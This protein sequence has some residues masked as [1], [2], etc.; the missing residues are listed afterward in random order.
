M[1]YDYLFK[2]LLIGDSGCGKSSILQRFADEQFQS[3]YISTI[4]VDFKIRQ[5]EVDGKRVK[6][7]IWDTA[8]Q[9]RFRSI[10]S[11]YYRGAHGIFIC[12]NVTDANSFQNATKWLQE[13]SKYAAEDVA[14]ALLGAYA[15]L[16]DQTA[17][18]EKVAQEFADEQ[19]IAQFRVSAK[20][21]L[22]I[23]ESF[24]YLTKQVMSNVVEKSTAAAKSSARADIS[25]KDAAQKQAE[26]QAQQ[27]FNEKVADA[28]RKGQ[29]DEFR[30][31]KLMIVGQGRAG[32]TTTFESL[33]GKPFERHQQ[34]TVGATTADLS[35]T[36]D[37]KDIQS[38]EPYEEEGGEMRR[39]LQMAALAQL[40]E[41][42]QIKEAN[43]STKK[44]RAKLAKQ[45][46]TAAK[47]EEAE[48]SEQ[49]VASGSSAISATEPRKTEAAALAELSQKATK[50]MERLGESSSDPAA[51]SAAAMLAAQDVLEAARQ[52]VSQLT[53]DDID[54]AVRDMAED[55]DMN[56]TIS[57]GKPL[58]Y[59]VFDLGGQ[60]TFY[61]FHPFFLTK[62]AVYLVVFSMADLLAAETSEESWA[63]VEH[64]LGCI[65]LYAK[66]A[67]VFFV[68]THGDVVTRRKQHEVLSQGLFDRF[69]KHAAFPAVVFN[70]RSE[71]WFWPIDNTKSSK[72]SQITNLRECVSA[73]TNQQD[74]VHMSV[75]LPWMK[76][77][78]S[79]MDRMKTKNKQF[80][81]VDELAA[82][83]QLD[84]SAVVPALRFWH[85]YGMLLYYDTIPSM[86]NIVLLSPQW[87]VD[88]M[89]KVIRNFNLHRQ[90]QDKDARKLTT[91]WE[92]LTDNAV[93]HMSLLKVLWNQL[94]QELQFAFLS[95]MLQFGLLVP[96]TEQS[97]TD[98]SLDPTFL[99]PTL[100]PQ[101]LSEST[102]ASTSLSSYA[103]T[104][105]NRYLGYEA[106]VNVAYICFS[107]RDMQKEPAIKLDTLFQLSFIPEG[108]FARI[109]GQLLV[110]SQHNSRAHRPKLS[111]TS[112][113]IYF[114]DFKLHLELIP[115]VGGIKVVVYSPHPRP[116][117]RMVLDTTLVTIRNSFDELRCYTFV[118]YNPTH[119]LFM[120]DVVAS[121]REQKPI[122]VDDTKLDAHK[123]ESLYKCWMP[124]L[125]MLKYYDCFLSYRQYVNSSFVVTIHTALE[126]QQLVSFLD[127]NNLEQGL[128]FKT[129]FMLAITRSLVVCPVVSRGALERMMSLG[130]ED[131][132]DNVLLEWSC[133]LALAQLSEGEGAAVPIIMQRVV[134]LLLGY[135]WHNQ[136][137]T[138]TPKA[139]TFP[140]F[141][142]YVEQLPDTVSDK[143]YTE[144]AQF[145]EQELKLPAPPRRS[146]REVVMKLLDMDA[147]KCWNES[148]ASHSGVFLEGNA[149]QLIQEY[150]TFLRQTVHK[151]KGDVAISARIQQLQDED[152]EL[153][154]HE[155]RKQEM[156][157][158]QEKPQ[159]QQQQ[160]GA[161]G[162][163]TFQNLGIRFAAPEPQS[164]IGIPP[165]SEWSEEAVIAW[166]KAEKFDNMLETCQQLH[167]DGGVLAVMTEKHLEQEFGMSSSLMR[168]RFIQ[169]R[170]KALKRYSARKG[171]RCTIC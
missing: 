107:L 84:T 122:W 70:H 43:K 37:T 71:L 163:A 76:M 88:T 92:A 171:S 4:G 147:I 53:Q 82:E 50:S 165:M 40:E 12:Y 111:R 19:G 58:T 48:A 120:E 20:T 65:Y 74:Y 64:W 34:S 89:C 69:N 72:C 116:F 149:A 112:A 63:F 141:R 35:V 77:Y 144:L 142:K 91:Q 154:L 106:D 3:A 128:N 103:G 62:Y 6:L 68:G 96:L 26:K 101:S 143:T 54:Q 160:T 10:T 150:G 55:A 159:L 80:I 56:L 132:C 100:L 153:R 41:L 1:E 121:Y 13:I 78:D 57:R 59:K 73:E 45:A 148:T 79:L 127:S 102:I 170:N 161:N 81:L 87:A 25:A 138:L 168:T 51:G 15:D 22:N 17:V 109:I 117:L 30:R 85:M 118:P 126:N 123:L 158:L 164:T 52:N 86:R 18:E 94:D 66:D 99:V 46:E 32:K 61:I 105:H 16:T 90:L 140:D 98:D 169:H 42:K 83:M 5:I 21:G 145:F 23:D 44:S 9:E 60:S 130:E 114:D 97:S 95:L 24:M 110:T 7:Q 47:K 119:L 33:M 136:D 155:Q 49:T 2:L 39:A 157:Q 156:R 14:V 104:L 137:Q 93:L 151:V 113:D 124:H 29:S 8:G 75:P 67:P 133:M 129:S 125:G 28:L 162:Q 146:T 166:L 152:G 131:F 167:V 134:P 139:D 11:S 38:W 31:G 108:L 135:A 36:V 27:K 115:A